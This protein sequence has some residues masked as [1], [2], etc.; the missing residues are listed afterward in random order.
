MEVPVCKADKQ[1]GL[2]WLQLFHSEHF[3]SGAEDLQGP[4]SFR[5]SSSCT[6][7]PYIHIKN[8]GQFLKGSH[9]QKEQGCS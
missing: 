9:L 8:T 7:T 2:G 1:W 6:I 3:A 4:L 5:L